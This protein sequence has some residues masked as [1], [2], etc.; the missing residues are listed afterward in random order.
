[1][2]NFFMA[3]SSIYSERAALCEGF[4]L[5]VYERVRYVKASGSMYIMGDSRRFGR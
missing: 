3:I 5:Y 1:M 2:K 4:R